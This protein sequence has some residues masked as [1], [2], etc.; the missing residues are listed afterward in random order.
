MLE[1]KKIDSAQL[2]ENL[3]KLLM[4][5]DGEQNIDQVVVIF[6]E[7]NVLTEKKVP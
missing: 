5:V 3:E 2:I 7:L 4:G 1:L 6:D